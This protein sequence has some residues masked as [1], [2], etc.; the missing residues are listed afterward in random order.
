MI[1]EIIIKLCT[2]YKNQQPISM[3]NLKKY[4]IE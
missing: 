4:D 1:N 3:I 2:L